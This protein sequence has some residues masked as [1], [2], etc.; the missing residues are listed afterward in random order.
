VVY[1]NQDLKTSIE[2]LE[3]GDTAIVKPGVYD[4]PGQISLS[5]PDVEIIFSEGAMFVHTH[6]EGGI[7][8]SADNVVID[9]LTIDW[10]NNG[11]TA[12]RTSADVDGVVLKNWIAKDVDGVFVNWRDGASGRIENGRLNAI[13]HSGGINVFEGHNLRISNISMVSDDGDA[14]IDLKSRNA[15]SYDITIS[16]IIVDGHDTAIGLGTEVT[17][18]LHNISISNVVA[19]NCLHPLWIKPQEGGDV[20]NIDISI[21]FEDLNGENLRGPIWS[22]ISG[23]SEVRDLTVQMMGLAS[24][25]SSSTGSRIGWRHRTGLIEDSLFEI[26]FR[27]IESNANDMRIGIRVDDGAV[28]QNCNFSGQI[29]SDGDNLG[30]GVFAENG[31]IL[32]CHFSDFSILGLSGDS[33]REFGDAIV[34]DCYWHQGRTDSVPSFNNELRVGFVDGVEDGVY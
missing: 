11:D 33:F 12:F 23:G 1:I 16:D 19:R 32:N 31:D 7:N 4:A 34:S 20:Y 28:L 29:L 3:S 10:S 13:N 17:H 22:Q 9:G 21:N 15:E 24:Y 26:Y 2:S 5:V 25:P 30:N 6:D 14:G 18:D 27:A 8:V